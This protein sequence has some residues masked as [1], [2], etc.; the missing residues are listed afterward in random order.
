M[1]RD[2]AC[3]YCEQ[4]LPTDWSDANLKPLLDFLKNEAASGT[5]IP[6]PDIPLS[7]GTASKIL[8]EGTPQA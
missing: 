5:F 7:L 1:V 6:N 4:V 2:I 3:P 8:V